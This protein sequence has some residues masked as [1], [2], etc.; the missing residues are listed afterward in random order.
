MHL[1][2]IKRIRQEVSLNDP[3]GVDKEGNEIVLLDVLGTSASEVPDI[4]EAQFEKE[5]LY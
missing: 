5:K 3:I 4:V 2:S 1:R